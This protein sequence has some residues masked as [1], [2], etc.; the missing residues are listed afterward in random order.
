MIELPDDLPVL[1][2]DVVRLVVRDATGAVL[3]FR[4]RELTMP[5]LGYWWE[6]PG[7]GIEPGETYVDAAVRE[8]RE[9]TGLRLDPARVGPANWRRTSSFR[10]RGERRVQH[11]VVA[12]A[13]LDA[14][15]PDIDVQDQLDYEKEDY[16]GFRWLPVDQIVGSSEQFYPGR[17]P[18]LLPDV[19]AGKD[20]DEPFELFS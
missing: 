20:I 12:V 5:E 16:V 13:T 2:R 8:L 10:M 17:L 9:E 7:G 11:E 1:E 3:L 15:A 19:L 4:A 6:L 14:V 18:A